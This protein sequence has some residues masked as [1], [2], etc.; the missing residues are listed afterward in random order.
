MLQRVCV[1]I[2]MQVW[3]ITFYYLCDNI[4]I[5]IVDKKKRAE[6]PPMNLDIKQSMQ[7]EKTL[8][9]NV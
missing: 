3:L 4:Y 6:F 8:R 2:M 1:F 9:E 7:V 5:Y